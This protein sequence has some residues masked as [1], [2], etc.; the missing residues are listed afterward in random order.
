MRTSEVA[1]RARVNPQTL[2]YYERRGLLP[3]PTRSASGYRT[4]GPP[5]VQIV[6]F[7]KRAQ[8]L[9]F[10]LDVVE[11]LLELAKGGPEGCD[12]TRELATAKIVELDARIA[13]LQQMRTSLARL[14]QTCE[15]PRHRRECPILAEIS[16]EPEDPS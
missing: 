15:R 4:Y 11:S 10:A 5:A 14:V 2:R 7:I 8:E 13:D 6:R 9:G 12:A 3:E 1:A 16:T